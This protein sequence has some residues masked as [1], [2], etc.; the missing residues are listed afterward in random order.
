MSRKL[1]PNFED[2][3]LTQSEKEFRN[4]YKDVSLDNPH[5]YS[6]K[7]NL[8]Q[9]ALR[10]LRPDVFPQKESEAAI[11]RILAHMR[12]DTPTIY[13]SL[14]NFILNG[15]EIP[16][17][18]VTTLVQQGILQIDYKGKYQAN[19][20]VDAFIQSERDKK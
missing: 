6:S 17:G 15:N 10:S 12:Q 14:K 4:Q 20:Y 19:S 9:E 2:P 8:E 18:H 3:N 7:E 5:G 13:A 11:F 1:I 16:E